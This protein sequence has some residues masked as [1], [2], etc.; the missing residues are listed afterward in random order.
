MNTTQSNYVLQLAS[1]ATKRI[2]DPS[3]VEITCT[4]GSIWI[5]LE[6]ILYDVVLTA[7]TA[8]DTFVTRSHRSALVYALGDSQIVVKPTAA[9]LLHSQVTFSPTSYDQPTY[10]HAVA[11]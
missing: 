2:P 5:T 10:L 6:G 3:G 4:R 11:A 1:G 8:D 9:A 7:G